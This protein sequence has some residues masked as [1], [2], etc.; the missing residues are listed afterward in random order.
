V[1]PLRSRRR[2]AAREYP[3]L[4]APLRTAPAATSS[5]RGRSRKF[6]ATM[7]ALDRSISTIRAWGSGLNGGLCSKSRPNPCRTGQQDHD[8][9]HTLAHS[10][11]NRKCLVTF[12]F[13]NQSARCEYSQRVHVDFARSRPQGAMSPVDTRFPAGIACSAS[14]YATSCSVPPN[15]LARTD[16]KRRVR[17]SSFIVATGRGMKSYNVV[18]R[19]PDLIAG[20]LG[21]GASAD[22][23]GIARLPP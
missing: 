8:R 23:I 10:S 22:R 21:G 17:F 1:Y 13:V 3:E 5:N 11:E 7:R 20:W 12:Y 6:D 15:A 14:R 16:V 9:R 19:S 18:R 2:R 4:S